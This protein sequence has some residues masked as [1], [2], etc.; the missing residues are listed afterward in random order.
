VID[1]APNSKNRSV[2]HDSG[3]AL[4]VAS[5]LKNGANRI[6]SEDLNPGQVIAG[7]RIE[8]PFATPTDL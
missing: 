8:N 1:G 3:D 7:M 4:I 5:A 2:L 6:L